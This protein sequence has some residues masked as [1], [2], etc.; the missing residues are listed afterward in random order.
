MGTVEFGKAPIDD[1]LVILKSKFVAA[2]LH[3]GC[4]LLAVVWEG[5]DDR[6]RN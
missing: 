4:V 1:P 5:S 2:P 3:D 6:S